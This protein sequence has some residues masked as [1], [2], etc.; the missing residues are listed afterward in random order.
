MKE[1]VYKDPRPAEYFDRFHATTRRRTPDAMYELVRLVLSPLIWVLWRGRAINA[2]QVPDTGAVII[3]PNHFSFL[4]HFFV[5]AFIRRKV[6][7]MAKSQ[8]F[9]NPMSFIYRH[10][11]V[12]PVRRGA[13]DE[14][15][16]ITSRAVLERGNTMVMY[17]EGGRSRTGSVSTEAKP[18]IGR[19]AL[20]SGAPILPVAIFGS[21]KARNWKRFQIPSVT[22]LYGEPIQFP[23]VD[24]PTREQQQAVADAV[25]VEIRRLFAEVQEGGRSGARKQER[26]ARRAR[27]TAA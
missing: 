3:A 20:E 25:L 6:H 9:F 26:A 22:V 10:G 16:F 17:C 24:E 1:Q 14:E 27:A 13:R 19:I 12:F 23:Q 2:D 21:Q 18:G 15:A 11:G 4:D 5:A 7:F 8:L